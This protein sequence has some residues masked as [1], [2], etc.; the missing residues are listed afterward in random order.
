[1]KLRRF[2]AMRR[3]SVASA[4]EMRVRD[5]AVGVA[6]GSFRF[7]YPTDDVM[8]CSTHCL[9]SAQGLHR[10]DGCGTLRRQQGCKQRNDSEHRC[11]CSQDERPP[12]F[13]AVEFSRH[14]MTCT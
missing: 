12:C 4:G 1:M 8:G 10:F 7:E 13:D 9:Q 3:M 14:E 6:M 2:N 5:V 11:C